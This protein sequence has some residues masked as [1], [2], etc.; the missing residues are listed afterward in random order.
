LLTADAEFDM[1]TDSQRAQ[2]PSLGGGYTSLVGRPAIE[3]FVLAQWRSGEWLSDVGQDVFPTGVEAIG[4]TAHFAD[5][6]IQNMAEGK[7]VWNCA[8]RGF[9]HIVIISASVAGRP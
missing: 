4:L 5:G 6:T 9:D 3:L 1:S 7:F 8:Q 2:P